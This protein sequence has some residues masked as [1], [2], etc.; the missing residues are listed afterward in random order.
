MPLDQAAWYVIH[1]CGKHETKVEINLQKKGL[2]I[3]LPR[4]AVLSRRRDRKRLLQVPLFPGYVFAHVQLSHETYSHIIKSPGVVRLLGW[5]GEF[6]PVPQDTIDS[7]RIML[8]SRR[9]CYPWENLQ[10]GQCVRIVEGPLA[11]AIGRVE[12]ING[13][14]RRLVVTVELL[15][16]SVA[17]DLENEAVEQ[18]C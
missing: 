17:V 7:I 6:Y 15:S 2:E 11:G 5:N 18:Y 4:T 13:K 9:S 8:A 10:Q 12:R 1:T 3:F 16:R 14:K